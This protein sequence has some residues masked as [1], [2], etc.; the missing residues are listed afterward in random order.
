MLPTSFLRQLIGF[1]GD[2]LQSM[3]PSYLEVSMEAFARNQEQMRSYMTETFGEVNPFRQMEE[4]GRR[5][6]AMFQQALSV[7]T[8]FAAPGAAEQPPAAAQPKDA[9]AAEADSEL[10]DLRKQ[11]LQMQNQLNKLVD[12]KTGDD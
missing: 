4:V 7:F 8:P 2:N 9:A 3:V 10:D 1:Y 12:K 11:M 6:I 5:N